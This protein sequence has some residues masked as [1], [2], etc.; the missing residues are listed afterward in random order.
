[1]TATLLETLDLPQ[2]L[3]QVLWRRSVR[4][5]RISLRI[6]P[7][8]PLVVV[9]LPARAGRAGGMA[10]LT[11]NAVWV[12][13]RL[14][15]LPPSIS[16]ADG[17][18]V[19][20]SGIAHRVRHVPGGRGG[21]WLA[22]NDI[23]VAGEAEFVPRRVAD[24]LRREARQRLGALTAAKAAMASVRPLR[25][26]VKDTR[27][28]WG[29]CTPDGTVMF[30]WRLVMAPVFVQDYLAAHEVAHLRHMNHGKRFWALVTELTPHADAA[31]AWLKSDGVSLLRTG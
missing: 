17:A 7:R 25:V 21:A 3:V 10:L 5:R 9:T 24:L 26:T 28:R 19:P 22:D 31:I 23:C 12:M 1:M 14:A 11:D 27:T 16:F 8:G 30:C 20:V 2:G 13:N 29:S 15:A 6:D 4:A 18:S